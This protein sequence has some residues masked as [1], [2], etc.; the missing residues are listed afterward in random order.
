MGRAA[1]RPPARSHPGN[2]PAVRQGAQFHHPLLHG[3]HPAGN[4]NPNLR[5]AG[6]PRHALRHDRAAFHRAHPLAR[7]EQRAGLLRYGRAPRNPARLRQGGFRAGAPAF[8]PALGP[9]R[10]RAGQE[11]HR[12]HGR[13]ARREHPGCLHHGREPHAVRSGR[14]ESRSRAAE[15]RF[16]HR[17]GHFHDAH[18]AACR[19][20]PARGQLSR[21]TGDVHQYRTPGTAHQR[22]P[23]PPARHPPRLAH[24]VRRDQRA[25]RAGGLR[26]AP[27]DLQ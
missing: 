19:R 15:P 21:K 20:D 16:P 17:A 24:P 8:R 23:A 25:R 10:R 3:R 9:V 11:A 27:R 13:D 26:F 4:G 2:G 7:A 22:S 5:R 18:G 12:N 6:E 14:G 1:H